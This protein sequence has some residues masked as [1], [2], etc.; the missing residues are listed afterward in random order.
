MG[1]RQYLFGQDAE[2]MACE[3]LQTN[4]CEILE[5]NFR[6]KFGEIDI[7]AR[8]G[9]ILRFVEV[10]ATDG[11]YEAVYRVTKAKMGKILKAI[12]FYIMKNGLN[13]DFQLDLITIERGKINWIEN[14]SL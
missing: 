8:K 1:L 2:S 4:G 11:R 9:G 5:R 14:I 12:N 3:F 7:V 13:F 6:S 10:K